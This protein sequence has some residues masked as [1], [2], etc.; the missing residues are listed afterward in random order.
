MTEAE[1]QKSPHYLEAVVL[2]AG[3]TSLAIELSA[4]RLMGA[5][6][7][8]SNV[9]WVIIIGLMLVYLAV[10]NVVGGIW[11]D[12]RPRHETLYHIAL[13]GSFLGG[14]APFTAQIIMPSIVQWAI[15]YYWAITV[16]IFL[17]FAVPVTLLGCISPFAL[18]LSLDTV[19]QTGRTAG[20]LYAIS[21]LGSVFGSLTPVLYMLPSLGVKLTFVIFGVLL[22]VISLLGLG[23]MNVRAVALYVW[24]PVLL[25]IL[26]I[27]I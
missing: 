5:Y 3:M 8:V 6:F 23:R 1:P 26:V 21:T 11:S 27:A 20:R 2:F 7:G 16:T 22:S 9:V 12:R 25:V 4:S 14:L 13:W 19:E 17:L 18:R 24:Q 10:G 15:P